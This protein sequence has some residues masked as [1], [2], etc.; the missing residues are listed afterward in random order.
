MLSA[1]LGVRMGGGVAAGGGAFP[2]Q[3]PG[4]QSMSLGTWLADAKALNEAK[5]KGAIK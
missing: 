2:A 5:R 3:A 4:K 1:L